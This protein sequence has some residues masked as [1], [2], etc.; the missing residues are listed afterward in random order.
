M[1]VKTERSVL[2]IL[3]HKYYFQVDKRAEISEQ[4]HFISLRTKI[5]SKSYSLKLK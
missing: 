4:T 2:L 5:S 1:S 3:A